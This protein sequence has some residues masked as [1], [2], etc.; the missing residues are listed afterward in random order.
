M[1]HG[2]FPDAVKLEEYLKWL[3]VPGVVMPSDPATPWKINEIRQQTLQINRNA[4]KQKTCQLKHQHVIYHVLQL[5]DH[6]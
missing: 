4:A 1:Y 3:P 6:R 2:E 5:S